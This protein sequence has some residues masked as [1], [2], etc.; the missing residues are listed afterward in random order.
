M[1]DDVLKNMLSGAPEDSLKAKEQY[2]N[3]RKDRRMCYKDEH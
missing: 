1:L 3:K 2:D